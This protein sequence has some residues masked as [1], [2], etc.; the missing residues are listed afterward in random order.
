MRF[1]ELKKLPKLEGAFQR[2][3]NGT[4]CIGSFFFMPLKFIVKRFNRAIEA[5]EDIL[6]DLYEEEVCQIFKSQPSMP[7]LDF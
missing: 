2:R 6:D 3:Y 7:F 5:A 4:K 1:K